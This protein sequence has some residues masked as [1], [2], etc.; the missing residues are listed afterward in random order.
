MPAQERQSRK[1]YIGLVY[2]KADER[3]TI[4]SLQRSDRFVKTYV[5]SVMAAVWNRHRNVSWSSSP[6]RDCG[7]VT[8]RNYAGREAAA[9]PRSDP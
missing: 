6:V 5:L 2:D 3:R 1:N 9:I 7:P 4:E 8:I